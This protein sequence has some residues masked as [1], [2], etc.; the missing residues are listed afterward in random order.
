MFLVPTQPPSPSKESNVES[1]GE[2]LIEVLN[3]IQEGNIELTRTPPKTSG[4]VISISSQLE[5]DPYRLTD[6]PRSLTPD[7]LSRRSSLSVSIL[8]ESSLTSEGSSVMSYDA[9]KVPK[10]KILKHPHGRQKK[11][12]SRNHHVRF[13]LIGDESD[14]SSVYSFESTSTTSDIY[15]RA[16]SSVNEVMHGWK[17]EFELS[18]P[19]GSTGLT[20][21]KHLLPPNHHHPHHHHHHHPH[22][23]H[24]PQGHLS[25]QKFYLRQNNHRTPLP[26]LHQTH[27]DSSLLNY[28]TASSQ[29]SN[30]NGQPS[31]LGGA[32]NSPNHAITRPSLSYSTS[33]LPP[34][35]SGSNRRAISDPGGQKVEAS[36]QESPRPISPLASSAYTSTSRYLQSSTPL[37]QSHSEGSMNG[38]RGVA[39]DTLP[40]RETS[41]AAGNKIPILRLNPSSIP[42]LEESTLEDRKRQ[43]IFQFPQVSPSPATSSGQQHSLATPSSDVQPHPHVT[44][45]V[46][47]TMKPQA[48]QMLFVDDDDGDDYDHLSPLQSENSGGPADNTNRHSKTK[49]RDLNENSATENAMKALSVLRVSKRKTKAAYPVV[50]KNQERSAATSAVHS[51]VLNNEEGPPPPV[52]KKSVSKALSETTEEKKDHNSRSSSSDRKTSNYL[53]VPIK[54]HSSGLQPAN[55]TLHKTKTEGKATNIEYV[56]S[57]MGTSVS[58][59]GTGEKEPT[60]GS[61]VDH[62]ESRHHSSAAQ[63]PTSQSEKRNTTS[64]GT[65]KDAKPRRHKKEK[66]PP[67]LPKKTTHIRRQDRDACGNPLADMT[68]FNYSSSSQ[69]TN[70]TSPSQE[71]SVEAEI[72]PPPPEFSD[73]VFTNPYDSSAAAQEDDISASN[74][75]TTLVSEPPGGHQDEAN[76][77][78]PRTSSSPTSRKHRSKKHKTQQQHLQEDRKEKDA[79][80]SNKVRMTGSDMRQNPIGND[81]EKKKKL[82]RSGV[83]ESIPHGRNPKE[84]AIVEKKS[85]S[86]LQPSGAMNRLA[87]A[88]SQPNSSPHADRSKAS[89]KEGKSSSEDPAAAPPRRIP[90]RP[91]PPP[92]PPNRTTSA[93]S[94]RPQGPNASEQVTEEEKRALQLVYPAGGKVP[95]MSS[96]V[97]DTD[98]HIQDMMTEINSEQQGRR[99]KASANSFGESTYGK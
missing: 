49:E 1:E 10:K 75:S 29:A 76:L 42:E 47:S 83:S 26:K 79:E 86:S 80:K 2:S 5:E 53:Q 28:F 99:A 31:L 71:L 45:T 21:G 93:S 90:A 22:H 19:R 57:R 32:A 6:Y 87:S 84:A 77:P 9:N 69:S 66:V 59:P 27:S 97:H 14:S 18:P 92:P 52:P 8:S 36:S 37:G 24:L 67:P 85:T 46:R 62:L 35:V 33:S 56:S 34:Q 38:L 60:S 23:T 11:R 74:S 94:G 55:E 39:L 20:P 44:T 7:S 50:S 81:F 12:S 63:A 95:M 68:A 91:A 72:V 61:R 78:L 13:N 43:H 17:G 4:S 16:R 41:S 54:H 40:E 58:A 88:K 98:K 25:H 48:N 3:N 65:V 15:G 89:S 30:I 70:E 96:T 64:A 82:A 51:S 73:L